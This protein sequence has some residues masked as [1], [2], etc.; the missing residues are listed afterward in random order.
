VILGSVGISNVVRGAFQSCTLGYWIGA[1]H[2]R[3]GYMTE[4]LALTLHYCFRVLRLHRVEANIIPKNLPS[5]S[6]VRRLGFRDEGLARRYL[7]I[8]LRWQD[9]TRWGMTLEDYHTLCRR[10]VIPFAR[11][12]RLPVAD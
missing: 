8:N 5:T 1:E 6:L 2:A 3:N 9:H 10:G 11:L 4:A 12:R 7:R